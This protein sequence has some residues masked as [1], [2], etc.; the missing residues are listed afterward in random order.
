VERDSVMTVLSDPL[1]KDLLESP[2][3]ARLAYLGLDGGPRVVPVGYLWNGAEFVVCTA[4]NAPKVP[5]LVANARVAMTI[6]RDS[7]PP[8]VLL[9]RG[10]ASVEVVPGVPPDFI[11]ASYKSLPTDQRTA[12]EAQARSIYA[13]MARIS[14]VPT[15]AKLLDFQTRLPQAVE[16]IMGGRS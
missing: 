12:F 16:E 11:A 7:C 4:S 6:D 3:L 1:A 2:L 9:V 10:R 5:A 13:D 15:W 8:R 14:I